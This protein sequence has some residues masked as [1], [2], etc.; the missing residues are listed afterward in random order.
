MSTISLFKNIENKQDVY[1]GRD[2]MKKSCKS[3]REHAMKII[4]FK[5]KKMKLL[6]NEQ[7]ESYKNIKL[8]YI[9]KKR[10]ENKYIKDKKCHIR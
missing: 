8:C 5:K 1:R 6:T 4:Y 3:L 10:F 7:Q 9:C 2:C